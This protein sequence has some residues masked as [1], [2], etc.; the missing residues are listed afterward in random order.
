MKS[1]ICTQAA[2]VS[3]TLDNNYVKGYSG[4]INYMYKYSKISSGEEYNLFTLVKVFEVFN[5]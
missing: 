3:G 4:C 1:T 5:P 2:N